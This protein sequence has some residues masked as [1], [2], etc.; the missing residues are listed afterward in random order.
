MPCGYYRHPSSAACFPAPSGCRL[1]GKA[2][3][4]E[5]TENRGNKYGRFARG[6]PFSGLRIG[7]FSEKRDLSVGEIWAPQIAPTLR[8]K[9]NPITRWC[10]PV[11]GL[12][13]PKLASN[14]PKFRLFLIFSLKSILFTRKKEGRRRRRRG[15][16][17]RRR[18]GKE[19]I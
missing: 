9:K 14:S 3:C 6:P 12:I 2:G 16:R 17:R 11:L 8:G 18:M 1:R 4:W 13:H 10:P 15:R 19:E 5:Q 7:E